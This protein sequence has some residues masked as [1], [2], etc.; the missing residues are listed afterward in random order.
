MT[1]L[2]ST[3]IGWR[4]IY[5]L[6]LAFSIS[7][8]IGTLASDIAYWRT[9]DVVWADFSDWLVTIGVIVGYATLVVGLIELFILRSGRLYRPPWLY[10]IGMIV[11]L[12]LATLDTLVHTRD[13]WT[14]VVPWG[15]VLSALVVIVAVAAGWMKRET[16]EPSYRVNLPAPRT[17]HPARAAITREPATRRR[18]CHIE[19]DTADASTIPRQSPSRIAVLAL[20]GV[21]TL[22]VAAHGADSFR[23]DEPG[24]PQSSAARTSAVPVSADAPREGRRLE[25]RRGTDRRTGLEDPG[26]CPEP[27]AS[28]LDLR[29]AERRH[30]GRRI[31]VAERAAD[32]APEGHRHG[33]RRI[34]GDVRR[35]YRESNRITL[36][37]DEN[38]DGKPKTRSVFLDH[39][40]SP[41]G[42]ALVGSDLYVANTDAIVRYPYNSGDTKITAPA[43]TLTPLP[44]GPID[45]HWTKSLVANPDGSLLYVGVGSNS[46]I[47][48]NGMEAEV[49]RAAIWEVDRA[50]GRWRIFASG[51][52][53]P[54]GLSFEP[55]SNALWAVVNE[56][57]ELGPDLVPDYMTS[58]KDGAF[59]GWPYSYFGQHVDPRVE[60]QR[61]DLVE[62]AVAPGLRAQLPRR[63]V[64]ACLLHGRQPAAKISGRRVRRR[65]RQLGP[66]AVQRLQSRI[67]AVQRR[68]SERQ[69]GGCRHRIPQRG[70]RSARP[71][72][73][74]CDR[75][76]RG[77]A[78]RRRRREYCLAGDVC[79]A[80]ARSV[81]EVCAW[82]P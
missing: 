72:G 28:A 10:A 25:E 13:A 75:Q 41:F 66:P 59:Y 56:R 81:R 50:T 29:S 24:R 7:C 22:A 79:G 27:P 35:Q 36:L 74:S 61:P 30:P 71:A 5:P 80:I 82:N 49:N 38:G 37:R 76:D 15:I 68:P 48:E 18:T 19:S 67:R 3:Q 64:G 51:L 26:P 11:A 45:H 42:V 9:A 54:N 77:I 58:V 55:E 23:S 73:G 53:N 21:S 43:T 16:D 69:G 1:G 60:P 32:S 52:R 31:Q 6:L 20:A 57:D 2:R 17:C 44:G 65:T 47:T 34:L 39:L 14:S 62:K 12:I 8:F 70:R 78:H 63:A 40:A 46:N 4:P 33:L